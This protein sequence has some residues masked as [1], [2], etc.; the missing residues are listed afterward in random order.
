[1]LW[2]WV[3]EASDRRTM[4]SLQHRGQHT[5]NQHLRAVLSQVSLLFL[6]VL[7]PISQ[8]MIQIVAASS[9]LSVGIMYTMTE[10]PFGGGLEMPRKC[11][12]CLKNFNL[13]SLRLTEL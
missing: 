5:E 7:R 12:T 8:Q 2:D 6:Y 3:L 10:K 4:L 11:Y 9:V 1:M 13:L